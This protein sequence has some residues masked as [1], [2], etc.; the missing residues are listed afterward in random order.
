[1][2]NFLKNNQ[3]TGKKVSGNLIRFSSIDPGLRV[4]NAL[5]QIVLPILFRKLPDHGIKAVDE[6]P[7]PGFPR[8]IIEN[9][10]EPDEL[11]GDTRLTQERD[12]VHDI[13]RYKRTHSFVVS[14]QPRRPLAM[15]LFTFGEQFAKSGIIKHL[16]T[17]F[18]NKRAFEYS[19]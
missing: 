8:D 2:G 16:L 3:K 6:R 11:V 5:R 18:L 4:H 7:A 15:E 19:S 17:H 13:L 1:M 14:G 12:G 10:G 9:L